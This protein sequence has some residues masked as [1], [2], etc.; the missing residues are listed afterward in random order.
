MQKLIYNFH[1]QKFNYCY[2]LSSNQNFCLLKTKYIFMQN[3]F[4]FYLKKYWKIRWYS[5]FSNR[6]SNEKKIKYILGNIN[7]NSGYLDIAYQVRLAFL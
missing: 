6:L 1:W 2:E 7:Y 3:I 5:I 4:K